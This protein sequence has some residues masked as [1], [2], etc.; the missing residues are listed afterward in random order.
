MVDLLPLE[1][2]EVFAKAA[3]GKGGEGFPLEKSLSPEFFNFR[4]YPR[5][6][7]LTGEYEMLY[8]QQLRFV[9]NAKK[10]EF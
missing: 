2:I 1:G 3:F 7:V 8:D 9:E 6:L 5:M 10:L 4:G